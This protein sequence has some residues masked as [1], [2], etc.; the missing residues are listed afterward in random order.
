MEL[1]NNILPK[2][3][4]SG[5]NILESF[6]NLFKSSVH[7]LKPIIDLVK[8]IINL[9]KLWFETLFIKLF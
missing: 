2:F 1:V 5:I 9:N 8:S 3:S 4:K 6:V 7:L